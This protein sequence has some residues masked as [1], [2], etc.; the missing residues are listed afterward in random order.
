MAEKRGDTNKPKIIPGDWQA[1][2][3]GAGSVHLGG[4]TNQSSSPH[5]T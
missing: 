1:E 3:L 2:L 4:A 5:V